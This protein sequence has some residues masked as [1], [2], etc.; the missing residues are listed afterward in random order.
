MPSPLAPGA[1]AIV[2][3]GGVAGLVAARQLAKA[4]IAVTL[5]EASDRL[6]GK[7][8][9][10]V[11]A[12]I[13]LD[14]G[15]ESFATRR[16]TVAALA[17]ELGLGRQVVLPNPDGAW[18]QRADGTALPL[19]K[20]GL[21]GIPG[22]PLA[23][24]VIDS[25]GFPA[26]F[27]AQLDE[28]MLGF[29]G[30]NE[31]NFGRLVRRRMGRKVLERLVAP[32][33]LAIHSK[34]PDDLDVDVVAPGLRNGLLS[35]GSLAHAVRKL[36]EAAPAGSA[37]AG[38]D[39]GIATLVD[40]LA[41]DLRDRGAEIRLNSAAQSVDAGGVITGSGRRI[42][43]D[44][45]VLATVLAAP[46]APTITL[47]TLVVDSP[48]LDAAPRGTGVLVVPGA[49]GI[50]A[51]AL[52]HATA[53]WAWLA[54]AAGEH[55]HVLRLSYNAVASE[56][57]AEQARTDAEKLLGVELPAASI[58]G[59]DV[60]QWTQPAT[61]PTAVPGVSIVGEGVAGTGLAAVVSQAIAETDRSL[62]AL[63]G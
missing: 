41:R 14:A 12:G 3:G 16:G 42:T 19:P 52:T 49:P 21:L 11:V 27:R 40:A 7:V 62:G 6:G 33:T 54:A 22:T 35:T 24:D 30:S 60:V 29:V 26:A 34:H 18:L 53:K 55:R 47:A 4:G 58:R 46:S 10:Q 57:L 20:T 1:S 13:S 39:G 45:I 32:I 5:L 50:R 2:V 63:P 37:V 59:F 8:A 28:L 43:A 56:G 38:L 36:R 15:A 25:I 17:T 48:A 9:R 61:P 44:H 23:K 31:R 51:K